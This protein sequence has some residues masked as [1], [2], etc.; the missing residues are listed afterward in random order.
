MKEQLTWTTAKGKE[1]PVAWNNSTCSFFLSLLGKKD[2]LLPLLCSIS[3]LIRLKI[4]R[5]K[6]VVLPMQVRKTE[7]TFL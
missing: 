4:N 2:E 7:R 3:D 6:K 5:E 1:R